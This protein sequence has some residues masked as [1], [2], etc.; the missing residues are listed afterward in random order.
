MSSA[1]V[2]T[3]KAD[4]ALV[5][6]LTLPVAEHRAFNKRR[7]M[8]GQ[9]VE[10][11]HPGLPPVLGQITQTLLLALP[12]CTCC[13]SPCMPFPPWVTS[14]V[15]PPLTVPPLL[16]PSELNLAQLPNRASLFLCLCPPHTAS[17]VLSWAAP[18][19]HLAPGVPVKVLEGMND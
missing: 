15:S 16:C 11:L 6:R 10:G 13:S 7:C 8:S 19:L 2:S 1:S 17:S 4:T 18:L 14:S 9:G 12:L 3:L 5:L